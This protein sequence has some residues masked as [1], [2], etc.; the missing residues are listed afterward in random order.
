MSYRHALLFAVATGA[1][2]AVASIPGCS[3]EPECLES[4]GSRTPGQVCTE[5]QTAT[6]TATSACYVK[7]QVCPNLHPIRFCTRL[8][9]TGTTAFN[10]LLQNFGEAPLEIRS[11][12]VRGDDRCAFSKPQIDPGW[13]TPITSNDVMVFRFRYAPPAEGEDHILLDF[14]TNAQNFPTLTIAACGRAVTSTIG[15]DFDPD[16]SCFDC[17][18]QVDAE[19]TTC[20]D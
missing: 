2:I 14:E 1:A 12:T 11:V 15:P 5:A 3:D 17:D 9:G 4:L 20:W 18:E 8:V 16:L 19:V 13:N 6:R 7:P 10:L